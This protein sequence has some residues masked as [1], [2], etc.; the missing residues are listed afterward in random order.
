MRRNKKNPHFESEVFFLISPNAIIKYVYTHIKISTIDVG[1]KILS[2]P[3]HIS[4]T[5]LLHY[6]LLP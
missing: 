4:N 5:V 2:K 6:C 3:P 1:R